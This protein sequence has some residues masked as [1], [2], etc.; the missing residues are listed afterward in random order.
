MTRTTLERE[1]CLTGVMTEARGSERS[2]LDTGEAG[3]RR[4]DVP[5]DVAMEMTTAAPPTA[6]ETAGA[7]MFEPMERN[8]NGKQR[9]RSDAPATPSDWRSRMEGTMRQQAQELMQLH[10]T[11]GHLTNLV[12]VQAVRE[13]AQWVGMR[14]CMEEREQ[15]WDAR[16]KDDKLWGAGITNMIAKIMKGVAPGQEAREKERDETAGL[17]SGGLEASQHADTTREEEPEKLQQL[18]QQPKPKLQLKLH[19]KLQPAPK[20]KSAPTPARQWVTVRPRANSQTAPVGPG[21]A[22]MAGSSMAERCLIL[23]RDECVPLSNKMDQE[24]A[25]AIHRALFHQKALAHIGS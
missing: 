16:H 11:V 15:K 13:E 19:P 2:D 24:I 4:S 17:D 20:P 23:R 18:Q 5:M 9:R 8:E 3:G 7:I 14:K 10:R 25:S 22:P 21:S 12:Q 1:V 6:A